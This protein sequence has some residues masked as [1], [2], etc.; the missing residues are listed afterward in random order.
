MD[1]GFTTPESAHD[2]IVRLMRDAKKFKK[3][4]GHFDVNEMFSAGLRI[5]SAM[6][7]KYWRVK[8]I[9]CKPKQ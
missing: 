3:D 1:V 8:K 2:E 9:K 7:G 4:M 6:I 5:P